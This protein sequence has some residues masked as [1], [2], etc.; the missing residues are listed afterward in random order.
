MLKY[1]SSFTGV[2]GFELGIS[3]AQ[4]N[5]RS[6]GFSESDPWAS[7]VLRFHYPTIKNY[8]DIKQIDWK[9]VPNFDLLVGGSPCQDFSVAGKRAG[10]KGTRSSL[11][12]E[13]LRALGIKKPRHF[14]WENVRGALSS[15][16]GR[17]FA[18]ILMA[19]SEAGYSVTWQV[20]N[21]KDFGVPQNRERVFIIGTRG[22]G[23]REIFFE[24]GT[25]KNNLE[26]ITEKS[27]DA[28]RVYAPEGI[29]RTLKG[30]GGGQG[31]KSM[32]IQTP[33]GKNKGG[34]KPECPSISKSSFEHN[35]HIAKTIRV[36]GGGSPYGSKQNWDSYKIEGRIRRLT[37]RECE[38]LMS[39]P[40]D[41]TMLGT[42]TDGETYALSDNQRYK[43]CGNG[44]VSKVVEQILI[45]L[46]K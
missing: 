5:A 37:P 26:E 44:V 45:N 28:Q 15:N 16:G 1:F 9:R 4:P 42:R 12:T 39:W 3:K 21:A 7:D 35:N 13:Y 23:G 17:D 20:L 46:K 27:P 29:G 41:W 8:G 38:R 25:A 31:A 43:M 2:G 18:A 40:D 30:L 22:Q 10:L 24:A 32:L 33:R 19:F 6:V 11:F 36:G 14:V 34:L